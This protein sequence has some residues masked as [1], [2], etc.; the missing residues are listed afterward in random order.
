MRQGQHS[1]KSVI[2]CDLYN[3]ETTPSNEGGIS[4]MN[5]ISCGPLIG[6]I[7]GS[8]NVI[9]SNTGKRGHFQD[10]IAEPKGQ[11]NSD[12]NWR[13]STRSDN[14]STSRPKN[15]VRAKPLSE[16]QPKL[17]RLLDDQRT[18]MG[19]SAP[20]RSMSITRADDSANT[21][22][23]DELSRLFKRFQGTVKGT[24]QYSGALMN[25]LEVPSMKTANI[26]F[27]KAVKKLG[28]ANLKAVCIHSI[29]FLVTIQI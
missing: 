1:V 29:S 21:I 4:S 11:F 25:L 22:T 12:L 28:Y 15:Q 10:P 27:M 19:C 7:V 16:S 26:K 24:I 23:Y 8:L 5:I 6:T 17:S 13:L 2:E 14:F 9:I 18:H 20:M 3:C